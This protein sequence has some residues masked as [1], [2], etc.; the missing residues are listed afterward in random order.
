MIDED[1]GGDV[2]PFV[3]R[4]EPVKIA[5]RQ[6]GCNHYHHA[7]MVSE[8]DWAV[9]CAGC[10]D[11]LDAVKVLLEM[12]KKCRASNWRVAEER[13]KRDAEIAAKKLEKIRRDLRNAKA[14][15]KRSEEK[16]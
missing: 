3:P 10:G 14:R 5:P 7:A 2:I 6:D 9:Y 8:R 15:L 11:R 4:D 16:V 13:A 1:L 12:A